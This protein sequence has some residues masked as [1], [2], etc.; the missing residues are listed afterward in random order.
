M[1]SAARKSRSK[2]I[3]PIRIV[4]IGSSA[5]SIR[6]L[7]QVFAELPLIPNCCVLMVVHLFPRG[8]SLLPQILRRSTRW[9]VKRAEDSA[10]IHTGIVY[11]AP[12]DLHL[13]LSKNRLHLLSSSP[14]RLQRPSVDVLFESVARQHRSGTIGVL[15]SGAGR[16]GSDGLRLMKLSGAKTIVQDPAEALF[17]SMPTHV[18]DTGCA[19]FVIPASS[20][21]PKISSL[22]APGEAP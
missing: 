17:P 4:A 10:P 16:D 3:K 20:I 12:P 2:R 8:K 19:D 1:V 7:L 22:C 15:L 9:K 21:E 14:V 6:C 13:V 5:G 11:V 18:V